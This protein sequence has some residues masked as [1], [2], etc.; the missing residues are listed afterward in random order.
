MLLSRRERQRAGRGEDGVRAQVEGASAARHRGAAGQRGS[1]GAAAAQ[2][3][4][5][6]TRDR[7]QVSAP[8]QTGKGQRGREREREWREKGIVNALT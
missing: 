6:R 2:H 3:G 8:A 1:E 5:E 4:N 7:V